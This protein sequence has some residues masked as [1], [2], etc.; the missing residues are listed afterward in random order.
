MH[1]F[2]TEMCTHVHISATK[3]CI[4]G[5]GTDAFWDLWDGPIGRAYVT[6]CC[7]SGNTQLSWS[8][9][10]TAL[11]HHLSMHFTHCGLNLVTLAKVMAY[12][13][14]APSHYLNLCWLIICEVQQHSSDGNFTRNIIQPSANKISLK[15]NYLTKIPVKSTLIARFMWPTWGPTGADRTQVGPVLAPWT[16]ISGYLWPREASVGMWTSSSEVQINTFACSTPSHYLCQFKG[17]FKIS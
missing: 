9:Q 12:C 11:H 7:W 1:H 16:L 17:L 6:A 5:Y 13:L 2:V 10:F 14:T 4:V 15:L 8:F 3:C